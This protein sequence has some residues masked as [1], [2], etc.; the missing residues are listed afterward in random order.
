M[1]AARKGGDVLSASFLTIIMMTG[2]C[3]CKISS[4][5]QVYLWMQNRNIISV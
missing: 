4:R 1:Q 5:K 2:F 3:G